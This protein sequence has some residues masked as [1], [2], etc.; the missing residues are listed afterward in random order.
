[1]KMT[2][3][4]MAWVKQCAQRLLRL[5]REPMGIINVTEFISFV[6]FSSIFFPL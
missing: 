4:E 3:M 1:M 2:M 6:A 5:L